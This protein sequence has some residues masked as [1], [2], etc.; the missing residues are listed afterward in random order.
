[1]SNEY[2]YE[3]DDLIFEPNQETNYVYILMQGVVSTEI[4][5]G[6]T[7]HLLDLLSRGSIMQ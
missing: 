3:I 7:H 5:D 4:S 1:M 6:Y 2:Q